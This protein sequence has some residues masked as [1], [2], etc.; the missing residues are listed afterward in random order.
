VI[1]LSISTLALGLLSLL[2]ILMGIAHTTSKSFFFPLETRNRG[3]AQQNEALTQLLTYDTLTRCRSHRYFVA[4]VGRWL[5][6]PVDGRV[7]LIIADIDHFKSINDSY[8]HGVGDIYLRAVG[9]ALSAH[10]GTRGVVARLGGDEF[11]VALRSLDDIQSEREAEDIR[12]CIASVWIDVANQ[13]LSR[14]ASV[15]ASRV[16][17]G[18]NLSD[19]MLEADTALYIAKARGRNACEPVDKTLRERLRHSK[20]MPTLD[21]I[22]QGL[23]AQEFTYFL[24]PIFDIRANQPIGFEAL[25]RWVRSDG[26]IL[27]PSNFMP[28][29][30][31]DQHLFATPTADIMREIA[32]TLE[33]T[34]GDQ[35]CS[36]NISSTLFQSSAETVMSRLGTIIDG[37]NPKKTVFEIVENTMIED[38]SKVSGILN[39]LR[40]SGVRIA[41]DDF[42]TG[43]SDLARLRDLPIDIVKIDK[44]FIE[45]LPTSPKNIAIL[46]ALVSM[47]HDLG[48]IIVAEGVEREAQVSCLQELGIAFAQG[49]LLG[50]PS[51]L[52]D[53]NPLTHETPIVAA[54]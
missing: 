17:E 8:G 34:A 43:Q 20:R 38:V 49:Y 22:K 5:G 13:R 16:P 7:T 42:G 18:T 28:I 54:E 10:I 3:L 26:T 51:P 29:I 4:T 30:N 19:A 9:R 21:G 6:S 45:G 47:S 2:L 48:Y 32:A 36:F 27:P 37:L 52:A 33:E 39:N 12:K 35:F 1:T 24:Q 15:G 25:I 23:I 40:A 41:L 53:W 46:K 50:A 11:W 14:T 31:G 44:T